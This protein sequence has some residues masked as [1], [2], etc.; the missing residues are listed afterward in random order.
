MTPPTPPA[1]S[2]KPVHLHLFATLGYSIAGGR[3][4]LRQR[5]AQL[6]VWLGVVTSIAFALAGV[7]LDQWAVMLALFVASLAV[8]ALNSA[9]ELT[10]DRLSPEISEYGRDAKDLGSFAVFC[11]LVIFG[12]HALWVLAAVLLTQ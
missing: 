3:F 10:V 6:Q 7:G 9:I 4:L 1:K 2:T 8:E 11:A 12:G 5:A